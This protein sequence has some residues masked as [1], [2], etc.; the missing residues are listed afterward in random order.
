[1]KLIGLTQRVDIVSSYDETRDA[2]DQ[3]WYS[4]L[5][6]LDMIPVPLPN[7]SP[8]LA[9]RMIKELK[10]DGIIFTGGNS[11]CH[12]DEL[13]KD[14]SP[15]RDAFELAL[16][17]YAEKQAIPIFGVCRG[18]QIINHYF[19]GRLVKVEG[20]VAK[21][22]GLVVLKPT[23]SLPKIVN[24][25]H[26]WGIPHNGLGDDLEIVATDLNGNI[27]AFTHHSKKITGITWHPEREFEFN[28]LDLNFIKRSFYD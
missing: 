22:H 24:S 28:K 9:P 16:I 10:L 2:L 4:L 13:A 17:D 11:L 21:K 3:R 5:L 15:E 26:S 20:H 8:S 25:Y 23:I 27:E 18:M 7:V 14:R 12:L 6:S 19:G 1:M